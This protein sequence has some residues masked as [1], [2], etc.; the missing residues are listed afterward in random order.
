[1]TK[2]MNNINSYSIILPTLNESGHIKS[3]IFDICKNFYK[4]KI[5]FEIIVVDDNSS[6]KT[7][8]IL[9]KIKL[10]NLKLIKRINKQK[11]LVDSLND[12]INKAKYNNII[13]MDADYSHP[14]EY[15]SSFIKINKKKKL[16]GIVCSRF[17]K[18]SKRYYTKNNKNP[19]IIDILSI[20]LNNLCRFFIFKDF[21]DYTSGYICIKSK[22]IK[23]KKLKGY[24]GDYF[25]RLI[26]DYKIK[27]MQIQE[28]P[29]I[30]NERATGQS[31]TTKNKIDF[32][33]KCLFYIIAVARGSLLKLSNFFFNKI[34]K[35]V[36]II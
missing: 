21:T 30:E 26:T 11:S 28:I 16:D 22:L 14:P 9:K 10:K 29:F 24:Y 6:D 4:K 23:S 36:F 1:M 5:L 27:N 34:K 7:I 2:Y 31:K 32:I 15:I 3:L 17:L 33:I 19:S 20:F 35:K 18:N 13:W 12:G 8:D 25:I